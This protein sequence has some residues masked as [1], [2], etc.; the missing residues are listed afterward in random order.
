RASG[1]ISHEKGKSKKKMIFSRFLL[2]PGSRLPGAGFSIM[3][4]IGWRTQA[5]P[6]AK[7]DCVC[8]NTVQ[9]S[10]QAR[11]ISRFNHFQALALQHSITL[12]NNHQPEKK[13]G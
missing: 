7:P 6:L 4:E 8:Y 9:T 12:N 11:K 3:L 1:S 13:H 5:N 2:P 10:N